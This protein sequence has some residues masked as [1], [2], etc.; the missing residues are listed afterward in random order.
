MDEFL[1]STDHFADHLAA[2]SQFRL[3][4]FFN[5]PFNLSAVLP[6]NLPTLD[7]PESE[8]KP[9]K[10]CSIVKTGSLVN[11]LF[12]FGLWWASHS[13]LARDFAKRALGIKDSPM[14]R[15]T[16]AAIATVMWFINTITW[17][18]ISDCKGTRWDVGDTSALA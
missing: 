18:P 1:L 12:Y 2:S 11:N 16:F 3:N 5:D 4:F 14:E 7:A 10:K 15:P 6:F 8:L 9:F 17:E 13:I